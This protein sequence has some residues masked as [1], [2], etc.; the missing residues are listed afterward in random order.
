M[1]RDFMYHKNTDTPVK[2]WNRTFISAFIVAQLVQLCT[3]MMN[4]LTA[5]YAYSLNASAVMI[6][7]VT[8]IFALTAL[9]FKLFSAPA[10]DT[11][12]RKY[13]VMGAAGVIFIAFVC[14]SLSYNIP[15]LMFSRLLQGAGQAFTTTG[16]L[17]I[18]SDSLPHEKMSS[19]IAYF[20]LTQAIAQAISPAIGLKLVEIL[21]YNLTFVI[22][23]VVMLVS[24]ITAGYIKINFKRIRA[25]RITLDSI[26]AKECVIPAVILFLMSMSFCIVN[27][28]LVLFAE[29]RGINSNIGLFFTIY[30]VTMLFTRPMIGKLADK[31]G[32]VKVMIPS[33]FC[34]AAAFIL[35]SLS[36]TLTMFMCA[37][38]ISAFGFGG[39]QP[40]IQAVAM[41]SVPKNRRGAASCTSYIGSDL[42]NLTGPAL[43]GLIA[44]KMGYVI[45]WR[46]M[47][48][49]VFIT[50]IF[51]IVL[52]KRIDNA[53]KD[54]GQQNMHER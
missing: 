44:E 1:D 42:G 14:Y 26:I 35:I 48:F 12:N 5:K 6:G 47:L 25:F 9:V 3:Q 8:G 52:K 33:L 28:F 51:G 30:A 4:T 36:H 50:M 18:A 49:P 17:T 19:G 27:S 31:F 15:M 16:C 24:I 23:A 40:A 53:G 39:C 22:L 37:G 20:T 45:M 41:R 43:A 13:I 29:E 34:F 7:I 2:V 38:F 10:L 32:T 11:Y 54:I 46:F 21:G